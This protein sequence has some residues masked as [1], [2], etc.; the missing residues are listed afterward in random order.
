LIALEETPKI[1]HRD[2]ENAHY[3][4]QGLSKIPGVSIDPKKVVTNILIFDV[5]RSGRDAADVCGALAE[6]GVLCGATSKSAIRMVTHF[7]VDRA[8]IDRALAVISNVLT[9]RP[10]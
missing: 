2:H 5:A 4:A 1:L 6:H 7:D 8:S 9:A 10:S 3:L